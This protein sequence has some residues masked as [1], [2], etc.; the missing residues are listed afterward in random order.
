MRLDV[1]DI[2]RID[3]ASLNFMY[4]EKLEGLDT[5]YEGYIFD[6][7]VS[8]DGQVTNVDGILKLTGRLKL[9]YSVKCSR[10]LKILDKEMSAE[11]K[12]DILSSKVETSKV[13]TS[14]EAYTYEGNYLEID[15]ILKDNVIL[16]LPMKQ[17]CKESCRG[18][19]PKCGV[20]L[21]YESCSCSEEEI[22]P[23]MEILKKLLEKE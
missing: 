3:G 19:C 13:V 21:N 16:N 9:Q 23:H 17:V 8:F 18:L 10:C 11:I 2:V 15:K 20:D 14:I 4:N 22:N 6:K 1:S 12:E 7:P 5:E